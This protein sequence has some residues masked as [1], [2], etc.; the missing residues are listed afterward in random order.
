MAV[1]LAV[2]ADSSDVVSTSTTTVEPIF[3]VED[4]F[5]GRDNLGRIRP[6]SSVVL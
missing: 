3:L 5:V 1:V 4:G 6:L 2:C